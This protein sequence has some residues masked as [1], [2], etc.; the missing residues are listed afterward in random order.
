ME[1]DEN[2]HNLMDNEKTTRLYGHLKDH[3]L[4]MINAKVLT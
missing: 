4:V 1:P 3:R 2:L